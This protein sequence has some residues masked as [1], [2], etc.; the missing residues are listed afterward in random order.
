MTS[1]RRLVTAVASGVVLAACGEFT[2]PGIEGRWAA[3]GIELIA[4]PGTAEL[5]LPCAIPARLRQGLLPDSAGTI[6]FST[7]VQVHIGLASYPYRIDFLGHLVGDS[8]FTTVT[9]R[10]EVG[11]PLVQTYIMLRDGNAGWDRIGCAQ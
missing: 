4:E 1:F 5:R 7:L 8:L 11:A 6:R 2:G 10:S 3:I 9:R